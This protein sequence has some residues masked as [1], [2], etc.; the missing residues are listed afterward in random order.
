MKSEDSAHAGRANVDAALRIVTE[1]AHEIRGQLAVILLE[2]G[3]ISHPNVHRIE[4]DVQIAS[5]TVNRIAMLFKLATTESLTQ[6]NF[7]L[8]TIIRG[9]AQRAEIIQPNRL[10]RIDITN[11]T[12][13]GVCGHAA[14]VTEAVRGLLDNAICHTPAVSRVIVSFGINGIVTIDDDGP[15]LPPE[16]ERRFGEPF[17]HG[18]IPSSGIGLG[19]AI[20]HHVARLHGGKCYLAPSKLGGTC[21]C[22]EL[23]ASA[24][25]ANRDE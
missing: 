20:A 14:F 25:K 1:G 7:D 4:A 9:L 19:F 6:K 17:V 8:S 13:A 11:A 24:A 10:H 18:R 23:P 5:Q 22:L 3:K 16:V 2:L 12:M 15:G 21:V